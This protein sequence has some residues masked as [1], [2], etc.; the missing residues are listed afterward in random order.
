MYK[1]FSFVLAATALA[2]LPHPALADVTWSFYE[3]SCTPVLGGRPCM[4]FTAALASLLLP[5]PTSAGS[6][7]WQSSPFGVPP[8][9]LTGD[10]DFAF[11]PSEGRSI[12]PPGYGTGLDCEGAGFGPGAICSYD[13][14]W[15]EVDGQLLA[16]SIDY[17]TASIAEMHLGLGGGRIASDFTIGGCPVLGTCAVTGFWQ[18]VP[19][20]T[21]AAMLLTGFLV[22]SAAWLALPRKG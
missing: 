9:I 5:G 18:S 7:N 21:S 12:A 3:T 15:S 22:A 19:E 1:L 20:P 2:A 8:P 4:P 17:L 11:V 10:T 6:A 16:I 13:I 14:S